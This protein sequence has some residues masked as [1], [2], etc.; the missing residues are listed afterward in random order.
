[1][2]IEEVPKEPNSLEEVPQPLNFLAPQVIFADPNVVS[3][4]PSG[5]Y[6]S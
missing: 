1:M 6:S 5:S 3:N 4:C 2:T